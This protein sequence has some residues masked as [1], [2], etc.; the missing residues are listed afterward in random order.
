MK[1][2]IPRLA[3]LC[4][5]LA[6]LYIHELLL[7][8]DAF[9]FRTWDAVAVSR[10]LYEVVGLGPVH[11]P[12]RTTLPGPWLPRISIRKV[13]TGDL[14]HHTPFGIPRQVVWQTDEDGFRI[15][16]D[17]TSPRLV[18]VGDS[19]T[20]G[21]GLSQEETFAE[22]LRR[23]Q[24]IPAYPFATAD[25]QTYLSCPRWNKEPPP[26]VLYERIERFARDGVEPPKENAPPTH[27][28]LNNRLLQEVEVALNRM[29][30]L[31][32]IKYLQTLLNG[33]KPPIERQGILFLQGEDDGPEPQPPQIE[34]W[35]RSLRAYAEILR[36]R[37]T[38]FAILVVPDKESTYADLLPDAQP[39]NFLSRYRSEVQRS[40]LNW[41]ELEADFV[42]S[43]RQGQEP[44]QADDTH[45]SA[46]GVRLAARNVAQWIHASP[47][48]R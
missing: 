1:K 36:E 40:G 34:A 28:K 24:G 8:W 44:Q 39:R 41:I 16:P 21:T 17:K 37:G 12:A 13:E 33:R 46:H 6:L 7:P 11:M 19:E 38:Q 22:V 48:R 4:L 43:R 27:R 31:I 15:S 29:D 5:P 42:A 20:V 23:E 45:W 18:I 30:R 9:C 14:G 25:L 3:I 2:L 47:V 32:S 35:V 10:R 26:Y